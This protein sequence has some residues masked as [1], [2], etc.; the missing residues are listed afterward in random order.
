MSLFKEEYFK[1]PGFSKW[2]YQL[3]LKLS[4][5][6]FWWENKVILESS[7][8]AVSSDFFLG[9][10]NYIFFGNIMVQATRKTIF[11]FVLTKFVFFATHLLKLK[12]NKVYSIICS[13]SYVEILDFHNGFGKHICV[14]I[15]VVVMKYNF[16]PKHDL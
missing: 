13:T 9:V 3:H 11:P 12:C 7:H 15:L 5:A 8:C 4:N 2:L 6:T 1:K 16:K 10:W 14:N